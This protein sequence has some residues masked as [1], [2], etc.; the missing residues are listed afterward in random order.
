MDRFELLR[1]LGTGSYG[2]AR[3]VR[4]SGGGTEELR[5]V[6]EV[7]LPTTATEALLTRAGTA[8]ALAP[9][10]A[11]GGVSKLCE[12]QREAQREVNVLRSL[13]HINVVAYYDAFV[14]QGNLHI[15]MEYADGGDLHAA[16]E[17]RRPEGRHFPQEEALSILAQCCDA[18]Q[19]VHNRHVLHRDLKSQNIFL[20]SAGAVKIGDFGVSRV[21][22]GTLALARSVVGTP[23]YMAPEIIDGEPYGTKAD[24]WSLGVVF[25][26]ILS[27]E[28][29]FQAPCIAT[30][31]VRICSGAPRP[32]PL[33]LY[34]EGT[35]GLAQARSS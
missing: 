28:L 22:E 23:S 20:T 9:S 5:V 27:L 6:K 2:T 10:A 17:R 24:M 21:L 33:D 25:H 14:E 34:N 19:H 29:P 8:A 7:R 16:V 13:S 35:I 26:E 18:L 12:A 4:Q 1:V 30:L 11:S 3:L 31:V 15:V 32:L